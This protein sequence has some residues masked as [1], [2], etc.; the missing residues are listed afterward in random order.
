MAKTPAQIEEMYAKDY[1]E[2]TSKQIVGGNLTTDEKGRL[3]YIEAKYPH[4]YA[5][6]VAN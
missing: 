1:K 4:F 6:Y 5:K 3:Y 2:L